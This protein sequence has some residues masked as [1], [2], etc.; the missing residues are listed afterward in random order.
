MSIPTDVPILTISAPVINIMSSM[1]VAPVVVSAVAAAPALAL[2]LVP[3]AVV[4]AA[5]KRIPTAKN[6]FVPMK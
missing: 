3:V 1:P 4:P 5:V 6:E 2:V